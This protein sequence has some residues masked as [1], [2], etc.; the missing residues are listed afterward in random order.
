MPAPSSPHTEFAREFDAETGALLRHRFWWYLGSLAVLFFLFRSVWLLVYAAL[1]TGAAASSGI[2]MFAESAIQTVRFGHLGAVIVG[3][4]TVLD[5]G[6]LVWSGVRAR[7]R[8]YPAQQLLLTQGLLVYLG[9]SHLAAMVLLNQPGFPW[10]IMFYHMVACF[11][12][13]W[14]PLQALRPI[15]PL[16]VANGVCVLLFRSEWEFSSRAII[17]SLGL[18]AVLPGVFEAWVRHSR[19]ASTF[20]LRMMQARYGQMRRELYDARRIH[21]ALF[22]RP[23][24]EGPLRFEYRYLPMLQI[25]GDYLYARFSPPRGPDQAP[26]FNLLLMDVTGHGIAAALTVNRLYGEVERLFAEDPHAGPGEVLVA[27]NRYVHLTLATHSIYVTALCIRIDQEAQRLEYASGGHP[28]AFLCAAGGGIDQLDSTSFVLGAAAA[29]DFQPAVQAREFRPGDTLV[30]YTDGALECRN[31]HGKMLGVRG[32]ANLIDTTLKSGE[33]SRRAVAAA[34]LH[35]VDRYR[36]GPPEDDTLIV[37][38]AS[39]APAAR[40]LRVDTRRERTTIGV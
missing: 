7:R 31:Q 26:A 14:T 8:P 13:P 29:A 10:V 21:E 11:F 27:L 37:E 9:L 22:P 32:L 38:I 20:G 18:L 5:V 2:E 19:R 4:L 34:L 40:P 1:Q 23:I 39:D 36:Y 24:P 15:V 17:A 28:P 33:Q 35:A 12:L 6:V 30:A 3:A 16:V 25:G